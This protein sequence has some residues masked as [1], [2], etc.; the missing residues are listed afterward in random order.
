[1]RGSE[2]A[3]R[4]AGVDM[5]ENILIVD[6]EKE[7]A[8]LIEVYLKNDGYTVYKFYNGM[9][10]LKCIE[11]TELDLAIIDVMLPDIIGFRICQKIREKF[12]YPIIILTAKTEDGD[13]IMGLTIGADD[14]ITKPFNPLEVAARVKTQLR[15]YV[16]YNNLAG[17]KTVETSEYDIR[18][19]LINKDTHKCYLYGKELQLTPIEFG[20]LWYLCE[21]QGMV[22]PSE[23][24]F[25]AVWGEKFLNNNNTVMAHIGRL[26]EKMNESAKK[27]KF[28]VNVWGVGYTIEK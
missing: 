5:N 20:I 4:N 17:K 21:H 12:Y 26:R 9:D 10:A 7:I 2:F 13:K 23:E 28:I 16:R 27:P 19:L 18:G 24:L 6:D 15:R 14:Y 3:Y 1:M 22:V 25:E 11:E 8:D